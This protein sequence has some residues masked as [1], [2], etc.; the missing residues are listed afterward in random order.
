MKKMTYGHL[1]KMTFPEFIYL[2][3]QAYRFLSVIIT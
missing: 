1:K 2:I 3:N